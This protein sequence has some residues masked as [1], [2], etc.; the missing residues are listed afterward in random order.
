MLS[1][2]PS[3]PVMP[4]LDLDRARRFY[5]ETLGLTVLAESPGGVVFESG[6]DGAASRAGW[7]DRGYFLVY[8]TPNPARGGHTQMGWLVPDIE[9]TMAWLRERGVVF[10]EYDV[11]G[12]KTEAGLATMLGGFGRAAWFKDTEG[13]L[14]GLVEFSA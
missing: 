12:V 7:A 9:V 2:C 13:N 4:A 14:L 10:E 5:A 11:P 8:P 6:G 1:G 3:R